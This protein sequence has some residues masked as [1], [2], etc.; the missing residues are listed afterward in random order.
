MMVGLSLVLFSNLPFELMGFR[1]DY[2]LLIVATILSIYSGI[3][4]FVVNK[5]YFLEDK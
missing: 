1:L 2:I 5:K 4:Y 3:Q